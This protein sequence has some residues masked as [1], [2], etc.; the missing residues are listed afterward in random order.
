[1]KVEGFVKAMRLVILFLFLC[2]GEYRTLYNETFSKK[3]FMHDL[4]CFHS[5][6]SYFVMASF[7]TAQDL[8]P[9]PVRPALGPGAS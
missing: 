5:P 2:K 8:R 4:C 1:M 7:L 3:F 6:G 9:K